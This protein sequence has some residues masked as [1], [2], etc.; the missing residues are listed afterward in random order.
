MWLRAAD[1]AFVRAASPVPA[2][3]GLSMPF[4]GRGRGRGRRAPRPAVDAQGP[5]PGSWS[6]PVYTA[7]S[8]EIYRLTCHMSAM[9]VTRPSERRVFDNRSGLLSPGETLYYEAR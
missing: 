7:A 1:G 9:G 3:R 4:G 5:H 8:G 6:A 2:L